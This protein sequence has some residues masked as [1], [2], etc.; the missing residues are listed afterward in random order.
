MMGSRMGFQNFKC[1]DEPKH[2][3]NNLMYCREIRGLCGSKARGK[4]FS[5]GLR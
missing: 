4:S 1:V 5:N 3:F 2:W